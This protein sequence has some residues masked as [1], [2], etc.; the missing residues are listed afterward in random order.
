[1]NRLGAF[2]E[3]RQP[4][5]EGEDD[6]RDLK[7]QVE[8]HAFALVHNHS[9]SPRQIHVTV[10][11]GMQETVKLSTQTPQ[12]GVPTLKL[13]CEKMVVGTGFEPVKA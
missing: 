11:F 13:V 2:G 8:R 5:E 9:F 6:A 3:G 1:M 12:R 7:F 4:D 10:S